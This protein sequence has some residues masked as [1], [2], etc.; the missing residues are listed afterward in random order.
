MKEKV[1]GISE[2]NGW[3]KTP[4]IAREIGKIEGDL[5]ADWL[6]VGAGFTGLA[7]AKQLAV[8]RPNDR[9][10]LVDSNAL[11]TGNSSRSSGFVVSLGHFDGSVSESKKLYRLGASAIQLLSELVEE[12][13]IDCDWNP[14]GRVIGTRGNAGKRSLKHIINRLEKVGSKYTHLC[15]AEVKSLSGMDGYIEAVRQNE[16]VLVNPVKLICGLVDSLPISIELYDRSP[17]K[18]I[19]KKDRWV[20][21]CETGRV[22]A[23]HLLV[24]NNAF[25]GNF[26]LG[27]NQVFPM[28]TF[29]STH[30]AK[31]EDALGTEKNWG[32]TSV[33]RVGSSVREVNGIVFIRNSACYGM[34]PTGDSDEELRQMVT[35]HQTALNAR[36]PKVEFEHQDIWSGVVGVSYNGAQLFGRI[37]EGGYIATG[38]NGHGIAQGTIS[39]KL[40]VDL[41]TDN[42]SEA[43]DDIQGLSKPKWVPN[44]SVLRP[45]VGAYVRF[46][47]WWYQAEL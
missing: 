33:E 9:V 7:A 27:K 30:R 20:A 4:R 43:L 25:A 13:D 36:F 26:Q 31:T 5:T 16:S 2:Q 22:L 12:N 18:S 45:A 10:I 40:L 21:E 14:R 8:K 11:G 6:I 38:F 34:E 24:T 15:E 41:A 29:V 23:K 28:R 19:E 47:N 42:Q 44:E 32:V 39:G 46:L 3:M 1:T 17:V 35:N 37:G